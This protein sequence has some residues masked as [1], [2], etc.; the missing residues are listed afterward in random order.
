MESEPCMKDA[1]VG[2]DAVALACMDTRSGLLLEIQTRGD[3][4][5]EDVELAA[6]SAAQLCTAPLE[7]L[8]CEEAE[9]PC[10]E[11]F[12][13]S[14][15]WIHA[16]ARVPNRTDLVVVGLAPGDANIALLR[17]WIRRVAE[18]VDLRP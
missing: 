12:V 9:E 6:F 3:V 5:R 11:S 7:G 16:F 10:E 18:R 8:P 15:H 17:M 1:L 13:A 4:A 14:A 2:S